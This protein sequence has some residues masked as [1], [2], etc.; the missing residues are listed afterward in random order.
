MMYHGNGDWPKSCKTRQE[1]GDAM[2]ATERGEMG[3]IRLK[4]DGSLA[5][6]VID[7]PARLNALNAAMWQSLPQAIA[8][9]DADASIRVIILR[10]EGRKAF[11]SGADIS[12]FDAAREGA[13]APAYDALN[14][15]AFDALSG[16]G[17]PVIAMIEGFCLGGGLGLAL[18]CDLR[19]AAED[20]Q[21]SLPPAKLGLGY[22]PRWIKP[23]LACVSPASAKELLFTGERFGAQDAL[24]MGL[25]N[26]VTSPDALE[27]E[28]RGLANV[29]AANA[30]LTIHAAKGAIDAFAAA[31]TA[32]TMRDLTEL[33]ERCFASDD[34]AE[35]RRAF[36][37][38]R[39]PQFRGR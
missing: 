19:V 23:L 13:S 37:E 34:Y 8:E 33:A 26:R 12:E 17:K 22:H 38:K 39:K 32:E 10:G 14:H 7:R 21:F 2:T 1:A 35:G 25:L 27:A 15:A 6:V 31:L 4:K 29:I 5:W 24:R 28:V 3:N 20:A 9:A 36:R 11:S 30:P 16:A 18:C